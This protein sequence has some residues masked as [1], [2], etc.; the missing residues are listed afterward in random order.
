MLHPFTGPVHTS[1]ALTRQYWRHWRAVGT[2]AADHPAPDTAVPIAVY[3]DEA[4]YSQTYGDKFIALCLQFVLLP[5]KNGSAWTKNLLFFIVSS[6]IACGT[7]GV[8]A[9][10]HGHIIQFPHQFPKCTSKCSFQGSL[11]MWLDTANAIAHHEEPS[12]YS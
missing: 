12:S 3:G 7:G 4:R 6:N 5:K 8:D 10:L 2:W 11:H 9:C 1:W